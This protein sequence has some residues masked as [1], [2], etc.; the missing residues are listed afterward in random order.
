[1]H[2]LYSANMFWYDNF[3]L[4]SLTDII[5]ICLGLLD[6]THSKIFPLNFKVDCHSKFCKI[7]Q[8]KLDRKRKRRKENHRIHVHIEGVDYII[9]AQCHVKS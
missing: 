6:V 3:I 1:M 2:E 4:S 9:Y 7:Y 8:K 5:D